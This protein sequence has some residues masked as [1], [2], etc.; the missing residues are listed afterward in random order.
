MS[1]FSQGPGWWQASDGRWYPPTATPGTRPPSQYGPPPQYGAP[2]GYGFAYSPSPYASGT[3]TGLP[4]V[5]NLAT[6][7]LVLGI[8]SLVICCY[9]LQVCG[10]VGLPLGIVALNRIRKGEADPGP[11][12]MAIAGIVLSSIGIVIGVFW[13]LLFL[14][15]FMSGADAAAYPGATI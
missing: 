15:S 14:G 8:L 12:G 2:A 5:S 9:F 6:A 4:S 7:S 13:L 3:P 1:D 10:L 11:K